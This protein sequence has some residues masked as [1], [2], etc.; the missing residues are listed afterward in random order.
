MSNALPVLDHVAMQSDR[1]L[2]IASLIVM[3]AV[4]YFV[5]KMFVNQNTELLEDLREM[6]VQARTDNDMHRKKL[7]QIIAQQSRQEQ[8]IIDVMRANKMAIEGFA[9]EIQFCRVKSKDT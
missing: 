3:G 2:F 5:G 4:L 1:W 8:E 6:R 7:E 9:R